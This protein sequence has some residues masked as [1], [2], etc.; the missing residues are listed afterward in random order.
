MYESMETAGSSVAASIKT[1]SGIKIDLL[2]PKEEAICVLDIA[3]GLAH[4]GRFVGQTDHFISVA[5]HSILGAAYR[6]VQLMETEPTDNPLSRETGN[7]WDKWAESLM[8]D[9]QAFLLHDATEAYLCDLP[10]PLKHSPLLAG[11]RL[12]EDVLGRTINSALAVPFPPA[13]WVKE[14][15][16]SLGAED[17][18][19]RRYQQPLIAFE[20]VRE[21]F[22]A[23][24]EAASPETSDI[25]Y[26]CFMSEQLVFKDSAAARRFAVKRGLA[27]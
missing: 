17:V 12:I 27:A 25:E 15:D 16:R 1:V 18:R 4:A 14:L 5:E 24:W 7:A 20:A 13:L 3:T 10:S 11:Y 21:R 8:V 22:L 9:A 2:D 6:V 26:L 23:F 19:R